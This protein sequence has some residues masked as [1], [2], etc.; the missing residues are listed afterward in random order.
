[1]IRICTC[2]LLSSTTC[3]SGVGCRWK[4]A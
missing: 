2:R 3:N 1:V 4:N